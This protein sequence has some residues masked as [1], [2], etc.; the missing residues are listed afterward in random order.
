VRSAEPVERL[1]AAERLDQLVIKP[2]LEAL[3]DHGPWRLLAVID[4]AGQRDAAFVALGTGLPRQP[5][6]QL[7]P[8]SLQESPLAFRDGG[9][10]F[11]WL[12]AP[13]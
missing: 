2:L 13:A 12:T 3:P 10:L 1:C 4:G 9:R 11:A 5:L 8:T 7:D 6:A